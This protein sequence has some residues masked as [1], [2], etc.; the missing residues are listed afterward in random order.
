MSEKSD[1]SLWKRIQL[2]DEQSFSILFQ[3]YYVPLYQFAGRYILDTQS[4][5]NIVQD[6]FVK[7]WIS[8]NKISIRS[9]L[10]SYLYSS[11]KNQCVN[12]IVQQKKFVS[13]KDAVLSQKK[14]SNSP[15]MEYI[16]NELFESIHHAINLLPEKC[17]QIYLMKRYDNLKYSEIAEILDISVNTV[18]TQLKRA[19]KFLFDKI[20]PLI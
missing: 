3:N 8:R 2:G 15:E 20:S 10:K 6:V 1:V 16:N 4:A 9:N 17:R 5:E 7:I 14:S 18:K 11:V 12:F 19:I 13:E